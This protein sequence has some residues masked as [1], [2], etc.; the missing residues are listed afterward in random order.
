M[1]PTVIDVVTNSLSCMAALCLV[2]EAYL[3][4]I[5]E[6][7]L[8]AHP[9]S[10]RKAPLE[11][12]LALRQYSTAALSDRRGLCGVL[13]AQNLPRI[14]QLAELRA[15]ADFFF[16]EPQN[17]MKVRHSSSIRSITSPILSQFE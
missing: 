16:Q 14:Q 10:G 7:K 15:R 1:H 6:F 4:L 5:D 8:R 3:S 12:K 2:R 17:L 9:N 11:Y 13:K